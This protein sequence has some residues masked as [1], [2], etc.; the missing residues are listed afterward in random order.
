MGAWEN[1][2]DSLNLQTLRQQILA[3]HRA[4]DQV[5]APADRAKTILDE[6]QGFNPFRA[7]KYFFWYFIGI[8]LLM[9]CCF[10][11]LS[12]GIRKIKRRL[13]RLNIEMH[14]ELLRN[15]VGGDVGDKAGTLGWGKMEFAQPLHGR[16][17]HSLSCSVFHSTW[18][19]DLCS[20]IL[21]DTTCCVC[22][23]AP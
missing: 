8:V 10:C 13:L 18:C 6:L 19:L 12:V 5:A 2:S 7:L 11:L 21:K 4:H 15:R 20:H 23:P 14:R 16:S 22:I 3:M 17:L 1:S 9:I